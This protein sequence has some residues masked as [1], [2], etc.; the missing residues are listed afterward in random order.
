MSQISVPSVLPGLLDDP[1]E[2]DVQSDGAIFIWRPRPA[3]IVSHATGHF[4]RRFAT[5]LIRHFE[6]ILTE[7]PMALG[8]HDWTRVE[9]FDITSQS[10]L[11]AWCLKHRKHLVPVQLAAVSP[12]VRMACRV[13]NITLGELVVLHDDAPSF[14]TV[15]RRV[16]EAHAPTR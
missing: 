12:M 9:H 15:A 3:V 11:T 2:H 16:I 13:A 7:G 8:C 4:H 6:E 5:A 10:D 1:V 14:E